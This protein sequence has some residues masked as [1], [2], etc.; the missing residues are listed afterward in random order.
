[1]TS[2]NSSCGGCFQSFLA[3]AASWEGR[4]EGGTHPTACAPRDALAL[5][6]GAGDKATPRPRCGAQPLSGCGQEPLGAADKIPGEGP[7][8]QGRCVSLRSQ[9]WLWGCSGPC[10]EGDPPCCPSE[11][12]EGRG[13][14]GMLGQSLCLGE[15]GLRAA[16][17]GKL[18]QGDRAPWDLGCARVPGGDKS[19]A[20][21][22]AVLSGYHPMAPES[23]GGTWGAWGAEPA[24]GSPLAPTLAH[25]ISSTSFVFSVG[26]NYKPINSSSSA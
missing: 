19:R 3:A 1:M 26:H 21:Q 17:L 15:R 7:A 16:F 22:S 13:R 25:C 6:T 18:R 4:V 10:R 8:L 2:V 11:H 20:P 9:V 12:G 23:T 5:C 24:L 14:L